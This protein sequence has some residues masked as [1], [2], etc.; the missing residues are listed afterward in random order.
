MPAGTRLGSAGLVVKAE[1]SWPRGPGFKPPLWRPFFRHHSFGSKLGTKFVK[2]LTWHCGI[3]CNLANGRV[4]FEEW[5]V[6]LSADWDQ[7]PKFFFNNN[8]F[9]LIFSQKLTYTQTKVFEMTMVHL[10]ADSEN[11][12]FRNNLT[13]KYTPGTIRTDESRWDVQLKLV[14]QF[15]SK[16]Y[17]STTIKVI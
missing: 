13:M 17:C 3:R 7:S 2:T 12:L 9:V 4:D 8:C 11:F 14:R 1:D 15:K 16:N 6:S 5:I 10:K